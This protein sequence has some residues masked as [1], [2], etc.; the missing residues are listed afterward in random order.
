MNSVSP[1]AVATRA[2]VTS[3]PAVCTLPCVRQSA[4]TRSCAKKAVRAA[5]RVGWRGENRVRAPF[6]WS[7]STAATGQCG[8]ITV[9][10]VSRVAHSPSV[11]VAGCAAV[12][13]FGTS[14]KNACSGCGRPSAGPAFG[15]DA[16]RN[17]LTSP[18]R[19]VPAKA[20]PAPRATFA[21]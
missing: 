4:A 7:D 6:A 15:A 2:R 20:A 13:T 1:V 11:T 8:A 17:S 9:R 16:Q 14:S 10:S 12:Q 21:A 5:A 3:R 19:F 18:T